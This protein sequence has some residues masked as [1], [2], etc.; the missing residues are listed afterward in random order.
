MSYGGNRFAVVCKVILEN[1][2]IEFIIVQQRFVRVIC[3]S[4]EWYNE[5]FTSYYSAAFLKRDNKRFAEKK[6][7]QNFILFLII[8]RIYRYLFQRQIISS[9]WEQENQLA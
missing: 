1:W 3:T 2:I 5:H 8:W 4:K 6:I 9:L 7:S